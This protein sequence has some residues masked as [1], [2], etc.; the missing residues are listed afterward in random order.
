M[1]DCHPVATKI[2]Q[3]V[4]LK[5][6]EE[7]ELHDKYP[8]AI[9]SMMCAALGT[10]PNI[11]FMSQR[12]SQFTTNH[13]E[14]HYTMLKHIFRY[15]KRT[16]N[17]GITYKRNPKRLELKIYVGTDFANREVAK[18]I[19]GY[20]CLLSSGC[21]M[22]LSKK[23]SIIALSI[24]EAEYITL[25][26]GAKQ[27]IW[28][29]QL[30][31]NLGID[32]SKPTPILCDNLVAITISKDNPYPTRTKHINTHYHYIREHPASH[33]VIHNCV[34]S[35]DNTADIFTKALD[36]NQHCRLMNILIMGELLR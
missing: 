26:N 5:V 29:C 15:L 7:P 16:Q 32:I 12:L 14:I 3:N 30:F 31:S 4:E 25:T 2:A 34:A 27:M 13:T 9:G 6:P 24:I 33:E 20:G 22:W 11:A 23:Q 18:S 1:T 35:K 28:L 36:P 8:K 19:P 21:V 17:T 10:C